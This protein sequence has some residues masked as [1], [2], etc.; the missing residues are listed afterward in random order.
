MIE[1]ELQS[2]V[3]FPGFRLAASGHVPLDGIVGLF[4]PS[5]HGKSTLLRAIAGLER[6]SRGRIVLD[7]TVWQDDAR[8]VFVP[9]HRRGVGYVFQDARLFPHLSVRGNLRFAA[10]R[11]PARASAPGFARVV[12]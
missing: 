1:L 2:E 5:G 9:P 7:G 3:E 11:A 4:G 10:R 8:R 6:K 12:E